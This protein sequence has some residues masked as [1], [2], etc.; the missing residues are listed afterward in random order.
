MA[1]R[2]HGVRLS[3]SNLFKSFNQS[4]GFVI[5]APLEL[6]SDRW[7]VACID[8]IE[9]MSRSK[10]FPAS[11]TLDGAQSLK[12]MTLCAHLQVRGV[13]TSDNEYDFVTLP[14]DMRYKFPFDNHGQV[15]SKWP[16][17]FDWVSIPGDWGVGGRGGPLKSSERHLYDGGHVKQKGAIREEERSKMQQEINVLLNRRTGLTS[18]TEEDLLANQ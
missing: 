8:I 11:Y 16:E 5:Q 1:E 17:F 2:S 13:Y 14:S 12:S 18:E 15:T 3:V 6:A 4:N 10:L 9:L 7:T